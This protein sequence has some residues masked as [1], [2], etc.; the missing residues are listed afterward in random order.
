[1]HVHVLSA[2]SFLFLH[3]CICTVDAFIAFIS[4]CMYQYTP[5]KMQAFTPQKARVSEAPHVRRNAL[6]TRQLCTSA[7]CPLA[8]FE[9]RSLRLSDVTGQKRDTFGGGGGAQTLKP[10]HLD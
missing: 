3:M 7:P 2:G 10:L 9:K 4:A 5:A 8:N 6:P 1:M